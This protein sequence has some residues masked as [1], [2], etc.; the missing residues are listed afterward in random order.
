MRTRE[1]V[2]RVPTVEKTTM[3]DIQRED[4]LLPYSDAFCVPQEQVTELRQ[5]SGMRG[6]LL[7]PPKHIFSHTSFFSSLKKRVQNPFKIACDKCANIIL[8][9]QPMTPSFGDGFV[10]FL[11]SIFISKYFL[12]KMQREEVWQTEKGK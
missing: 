9:G 8:D 1:D 12:L 5:T 4:H 10:Y 6:M 7:Y 11:T 2:A 3:R